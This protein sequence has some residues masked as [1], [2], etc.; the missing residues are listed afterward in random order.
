VHV[1]EQVRPDVLEQRRHWFK[2]QL[3]LDPLKLVFVDETGAK[4]NMARR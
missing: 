4:T 1:S 2:G 3:D